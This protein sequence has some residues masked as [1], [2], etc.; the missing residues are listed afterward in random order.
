VPMQ[1]ALVDLDP[2]AGGHLLG[3]DGVLEVDVPPGALTAADI[4]A[5][6]GKARLLVRQVLPPSG[7]SAGGSGH[8]TFGTFLFQVVGAD[9]RLARGLH[10][11]VQ[12]TLHYDERAA[13][14][15]LS[16]VRAVVNGSLPKWV[17]LDPASVKVQSPSPSGPSSP[18]SELSVRLLANVQA[19]S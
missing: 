17:D 3:S 19:A 1:P 15:D 5:S 8:F 6:G 4:S 18:S 11:P 10:K 16:H 13:A 9:G 2:A 14:L 12:V 7:S